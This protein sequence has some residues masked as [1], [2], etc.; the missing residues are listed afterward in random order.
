MLKISEIISRAALP[1]VFGFIACF[2]ILFILTYWGMPF[3]QVIYRWQALIA[4]SFALFGACLTI[5]RMRE[6]EED[7]IYRSSLASRALLSDA[8]SELNDYLKDCFEYIYTEDYQLPQTPK[9]IQIIKNHIQYADKKTAVNLYCII[10]F[11]QIHRSRISGYDGDKSINKTKEKFT[12][13]V[14][15]L[16]ACFVEMWNYARNTQETYNLPNFNEAVLH[17]ANSQINKYPENTYYDVQ[18]YIEKHSKEQISKLKYN[19]DFST[20]EPLAMIS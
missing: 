12:L 11:F 18:K 19:Y 10:S 16:S 9:A 3:D 6:I 1:F 8:L 15:S 2:L 17:N 20:K 4:G 14:L 7:K 5:W 13:D